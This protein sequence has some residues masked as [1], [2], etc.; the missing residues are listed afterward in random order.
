MIRIGEK[1]HGNWNPPDDIIKPPMQ[2]LESN[3][4]AD[5]QKKYNIDIHKSPYTYGLWED[6][7]MRNNYINL[8]Y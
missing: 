2:I 8:I 5:Y 1:C 4:F 3:Y 6:P 7:R